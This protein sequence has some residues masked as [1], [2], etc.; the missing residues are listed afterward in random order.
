MSDR[1]YTVPIINS[2][3]TPIGATGRTVQQLA[4]KQW[5]DA[6]IIAPRSGSMSVGIIC[7]STM[8]NPAVNIWRGYVHGAD[9]IT[10]EWNNP[11]KEI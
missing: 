6:G 3:G 7:S 2:T 4:T 10:E 9:H 1:Y 11:E 5:I 8:T